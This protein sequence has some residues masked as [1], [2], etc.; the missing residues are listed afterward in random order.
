MWPQSVL[1]SSPFDEGNQVDRRRKERCRFGIR[2]G[3]PTASPRVPLPC[4]LL[5]WPHDSPDSPLSPTGFHNGDTSLSRWSWSKSGA[6]SP[7]SISPHERPVPA[8][9]AR[10]AWS[11]LFARKQSCGGYAT[12][13][14]VTASVWNPSIQG[15]AQVSS[16]QQNVREIFESPPLRVLP[17]LRPTRES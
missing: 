15:D 9:A 13:T 6:T 14:Q 8:V 7:P 4:P 16:F 3:R 11:T 12:A 1:S 10:D 2:C 17:F 5:R